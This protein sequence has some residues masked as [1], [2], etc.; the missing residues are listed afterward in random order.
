MDE[1]RIDFVLTWVNGADKKWLGKKNQYS[2]EKVSVNTSIIRYRDWDVLKYWF[3]AVERY[4]P[5]V[6]KIFIIMD[7]QCPEWL[8]T[9]ND[10]I[11]VVNHSEFIPEEY[12]P[13]FNSRAIELNMHRIKGLSEN[14]VYFND[15][16]FLN[17][18]TKPSDFFR[19]GLPV[20]VG[21][22]NTV[23]SNG[24]S[25]SPVIFHNMEIINKKFNKK[26]QLHK[27]IF[28]FINLKYGKY[29]Y[30]T[31][32]LVAWP[33]YQGFVNT[34]GPIAF[35]K[36]SFKEV[37]DYVPEECQKTCLNKFR[38]SEGINLWLIR[39]WQLASG[40]FYPGRK[41]ANIYYDISD[42]IENSFDQI[43]NAKNKCICLNDGSNITDFET[44]KE[45]L[46]TAFQKKFPNKSIFEIDK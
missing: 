11:Q 7:N 34:H 44:T 1:D 12:L 38:H 43:L 37:W 45:K 25:L 5:W 22:F 27:N 30:R 4:A 6:N 16:M 14:F 29:N 35:K 23:P 28:K 17:S 24:N 20:D 31:L 18:L 42:E 10:K 19:K 40:T 33:L 15:D 32:L 9:S 26:E 13:T 39:Y 41:K 21:S 3:R 46:V 2:K 8:E 36:S